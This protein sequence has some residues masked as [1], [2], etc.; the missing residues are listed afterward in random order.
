MTKNYNDNNNLFVRVAIASIIIT[1]LLSY[2][3]TTVSTHAQAQSQTQ[4][5]DSN[6]S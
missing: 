2:A 6:I 3:L 1:S 5:F 4:P